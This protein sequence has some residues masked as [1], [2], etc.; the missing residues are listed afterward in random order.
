MVILRAKEED[1]GL[2]CELAI[3]MYSD[4]Q[5]AFSETLAKAK[6]RT[7]EEWDGGAKWLPVSNEVFG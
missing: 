4:S 6:Q 1:G 2:L 7:V 3:Q 5:D